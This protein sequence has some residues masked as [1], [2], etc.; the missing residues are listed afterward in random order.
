[1]IDI[2]KEI[3]SAMIAKDK[4][5]LASL[6]AVKSAFILANTEK[7]AEELNPEGQIKIIQKQVKQRKEA[8]VIYQQQGRSDL[9]Q[10]ELAQVAILESFLPDQM[11]ETEVTEA[12]KEIIADLGAKTM[13]D[14]GKV[15]GVASKK[16]SA[17]ADGKIIAAQ[18]RKLLT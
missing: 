13:S 3:K 1:M 6:R 12:V 16:L 7:G 8:A 9:V 11:S 2:N 5:R 18:V 10:E 14:M 17:N 4:V 15:M